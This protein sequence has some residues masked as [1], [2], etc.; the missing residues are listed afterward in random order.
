MEGEEEE[1]RAGPPPQPTPQF[2]FSETPDLR[3]R[4]YD[5]MRR[6]EQEKLQ[7]RSMGRWS[8]DVPDPPMPNLKPTIAFHRHAKAFA[9]GSLHVGMGLYLSLG[10]PVPTFDPDKWYMRA[11]KGMSEGERDNILKYFTWESDN[12]S[13]M[14]KYLDFNQVRD[15]VFHAVAMGYEFENPSH[16][17]TAEENRGNIIVMVRSASPASACP[18]S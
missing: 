8:S 9:N 4:F 15:A 5:G 2:Q 1:P 6:H 7:R 12:I 13:W 18:S 11:S 10:S 14:A 3:T 16:R 17:T